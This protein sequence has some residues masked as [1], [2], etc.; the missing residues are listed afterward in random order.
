MKTF[1]V[2][3]V[4]AAVL[5]PAMAND[6]SSPT[7]FI[8]D[9]LYIFVQSPDAIATAEPVATTSYSTAVAEEQTTAVEP[10]SSAPHESPVAPAPSSSS[11]AYVQPSSSS[12]AYE[13]QPTSS[14]GIPD[15]QGNNFKVPSGAVRFPWNY[16]NADKVVPITPMAE[17]GGWA[18]SPNQLCKPNSWC[19]YACESGYYS[20]QWDPT[21]LIYNGAGSMN[22]GLYADA[23]GVLTKPYPSKAFCEPGLFNANIRNTL[24]QSVS[25]CQ[26]IYPGNEAMLIPTVAQ[27]GG[28]APLNVVPHS[29]WLGTSAQFYVNLA[30]STDAQCVW[31]TAAAP[32]GNWG[33]FIFGAG[34]GADGNTYISVQY[35]PLYLAAGFKAADTY[36]V[37]IECDSGSCNFP[38]G[39]QCKCE[40]GTCSVDNGCTVALAGGAKASFVIY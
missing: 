5:S 31:G 13:A 39:G 34:Q 3:A 14:G 7:Q 17:N 37:K 2:L 23:N 25:A 28:T 1:A 35:N 22:G 21:A 33:P 12:S 40:Q 30:G 27:G 26:T 16:N 24:G 32:V 15:G 36:N 8:G 19:P 11:S 9:P 4:L 18:M 6:A 10:V 20:A 38:A 29:Y